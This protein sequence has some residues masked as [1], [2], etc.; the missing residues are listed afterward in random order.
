MKL[1]QQNAEL[2]GMLSAQSKKSSSSKEV[3]AKAPKKFSGNDKEDNFKQWAAIMLMNLKLKKQSSK[4][5]VS[6][7]TTHLEDNALTQALLIQDRNP[8]I[9]WDAFI[10][11]MQ[12]ALY[13]RDPNIQAR[14]ALHRAYL[15][16]ASD[17]PAF[18]YEFSKNLG[19]VN[20]SEAP[21]SELDAIVCFK[22]AVRETAYHK[23]TEVNP[24]TDTAYTTL[25]PIIERC[26]A[27]Y[28]SRYAGKSRDK[29]DSGKTYREFGNTSYMNKRGRGR[30]TERGGRTFRG[31]RGYNRGFSSSYQ[32]SNNYNQE[33]S[34]ERNRG[35]RGRG[36]E[37][38][39]GRGNNSEGGRGRER[40]NPSR[41]FVPVEG[42]RANPY[43]ICGRCG[44][45]G[46][47]HSECPSEHGDSRYQAPRHRRYGSN[48]PFSPEGNE[49]FSASL[50][51]LFSELPFAPS[52]F[53]IKVHMSHKKVNPSTILIQNKRKRQKATEA[54][55]ATE[56]ENNKSENK[57]NLF[58]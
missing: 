15:K 3:H 22:A 10:T 8:N 13:H 24:R 9:G 52:P 58:E 7:A 1:A 38:G 43:D 27:V 33:R 5:Y 46:H 39:R 30:S 12:R 50:Q 36:N 40:E 51:A 55:K 44:N 35:N 48:P 2:K 28:E 29:E 16:Q 25:K 53:P 18:S 57:D 21:M 37:R 32:N 42:T 19:I 49:D 34:F 45:R 56:A 6:S 20:A 54:K 17:F 14:E 11:E 23:E 47:W 31:G 41:R 4:D 26:Q